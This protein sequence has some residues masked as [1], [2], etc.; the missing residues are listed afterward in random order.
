M[1]ESQFF[2][3]PEEK[4]EFYNFVSQIK[5]GGGGDEP[6]SGLEALALALR[7]DFVKDG[8]KSVM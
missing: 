8:D 3:L 2:I 7:S 4:Q 5:A 1:E 6:E